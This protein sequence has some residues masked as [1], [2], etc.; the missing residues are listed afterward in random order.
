MI[1]LYYSPGTACLAP[2]F[3]LEELGLPYELVLVDTEKKQHQEAAYLQLNPKGTIPFL[4]DD[5]LHLS[6]SA[7]ICFYLSENYGKHE[8]ASSTD[9]KER[10]QLLQW[11]M[12]LSNTLQAELLSYF[13]PERLTEDAI[14]AAQVKA[15][16]TQRIALML[17]LIDQKLSESNCAYLLGE[18]ISIADL[19]LFMLCR[20]TRGMQKPARVYPHLNPYL[21]LLLQRPAIVKAFTMEGLAAPYY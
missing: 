18:Q 2:H 4:I 7:A 17:D 5:H 12:Y 9:V 20:W 13:Y 1:Q 14:T 3:L 11:L 21:A 10:A 19:F 8:F 6:E 15:K 16:A